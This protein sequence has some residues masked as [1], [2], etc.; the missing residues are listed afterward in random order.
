MADATRRS[1]YQTESLSVEYDPENGELLVSALLPALTPPKTAVLS[2]EDAILLHQEIGKML[3][4][5]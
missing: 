3:G 4:V 5:E 2:H 1:L